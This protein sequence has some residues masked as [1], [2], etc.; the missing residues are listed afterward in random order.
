MYDDDS[1]IKNWEKIY[2]TK[3]FGI[4]K[5]DDITQDFFIKLIQQ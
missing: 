4:L 3:D 5:F 1:K 2:S